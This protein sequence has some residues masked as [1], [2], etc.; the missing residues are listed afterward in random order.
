ML[1]PT[2]TFL[3][4]MTATFLVLQTLLHLRVGI[5]RNADVLNVGSDGDVVESDGDVLD[6]LTVVNWMW[7]G[8][9]IWPLSLDD[10]KYL[11]Q[12]GDRQIR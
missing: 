8:F 7:F 2:A 1:N 9:G 5:V 10:T 11:V 3:M 6:D 4:L 12:V